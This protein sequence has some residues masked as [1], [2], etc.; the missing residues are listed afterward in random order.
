VAEI[1]ALIEGESL[2]TNIAPVEDN[3]RLAARFAT[4]SLKIYDSGVS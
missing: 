3:A 2:K 4:G 1:H